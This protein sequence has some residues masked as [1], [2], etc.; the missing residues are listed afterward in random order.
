[1]SGLSQTSEVC[2]WQRVCQAN[3]IAKRNVT[4][5]LAN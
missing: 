1:M 2:S 3:L 4:K 5:L